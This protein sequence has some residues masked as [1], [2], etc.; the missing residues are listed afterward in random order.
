MSFI[1]LNH[2]RINIQP[3]EDICFVCGE[4]W[5]TRKRYYINDYLKENFPN[6][7]EVDI[8]A[9]H[10]GCRSLVLRREKLKKE[11]LDLE[12]KIFLKRFR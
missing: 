12:Y 11:L 6:M 8:I 4:K 5:N 10:A 7:K 2:E 1:D 3:D 9:G